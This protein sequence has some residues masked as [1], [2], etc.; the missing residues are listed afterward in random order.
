MNLKGWRKSN[1]PL[2]A[3]TQGHKVNCQICVNTCLDIISKM[4]LPP[5]QFSLVRERKQRGY[6]GYSA[7][8]EVSRGHFSLGLPQ[9]HLVEAWG[10]RCAW[11]QNVFHPERLM[12]VSGPGAALG[13]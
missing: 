11:F 13:G 3:K 1:P 8:K 2:G 9:R 6:L 5:T 7:G 12:P 4:F 10:F